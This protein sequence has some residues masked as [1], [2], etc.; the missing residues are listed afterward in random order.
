MFI[1]PVIYISL[2]FQLLKK[3][4]SRN[5]NGLV[6][7]VIFALP[8]YTIAMSV[9][10]LM[11]F[12]KLVPF[13]QS[14]KEAGILAALVYLLYHLTKWYRWHII[15][16]L[17]IGFFFYVLIYVFLPLGSYGFFQKV[18]AFKSLCFFPIVYFT[19][20]LIPPSSFRLGETFQYL[21]ILAIIA[22]AV[23]LY[24]VVTYTHIQTFTGYAD[25]NYRFFNQEPSGSYGLSWTFEI[26]N[27]MKRFASIFST[28]LE[29]AAATLISVSALVAMSTTNNNKLQFT[30]F[31]LFTAACTLFC[32]AMAL[33]R[34]S[35]VSYFFI[36]YAYA[37]ITG[38]KWITRV[39]HYG[40]LS[41]VAFLLLVTFNNDFYD[42]IINSIQFTN[43]SS[44]GHLIEWL[45]GIDSM[46]RHPLGIGLGE[47]G[48]ISAFA[49]DNTGGENQFIII[50]V[51]AGVIALAL[52]ILVYIRLIKEGIKAFRTRAGVQRQM[53]I[54]ILLVKAGLLIPLFTAEVESY[55][56][57][58]Y[59]TWFLSGCF[60]SM[61]TVE[62][63]GNEITLR[64]T[65]VL[66]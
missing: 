66:K 3:L 4:F 28:P 8:L 32:I 9:T 19:G 7:F 1:F 16:L 20:R 50:G 41:V 47:S 34:A 43:G 30:K 31:N 65:E 29:F 59:L 56:Y 55:I 45:N 36:I 37:Y 21:C 26:E 15:D 49:G 27:G 40:A 5:M 42:F 51:Q 22:A 11:G 17:L 23:N 35:F 25:Y 64:T 38:Q 13:L 12:P 63:P 46:I 61:I 39:F 48:R 24:E 57:V 60:I 2:F 18:L 14:C 10:N 54:F 58:S 53:G 52:Y 33:S 44:V 62:K 6:L